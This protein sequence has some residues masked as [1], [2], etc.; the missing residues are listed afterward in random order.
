MMVWLLARIACAAVTLMVVGLVALGAPLPDATA[1]TP[2][3]SSAILSE[4]VGLGARPSVR[5]RRVQRILARRK[6]D[7]GSPGVDGRFGPLTA[8]AVRRLQERYGLVPDGIVGPKTL[9]LLRLLAPRRGT[10]RPARPQPPVQ[11]T[12]PRQ[13]SRTQESAATQPRPATHVQTAEQAGSID[14]PMVLAI[15]AALLAAAALAAALLG[16]QRSAKALALTSIERELLLEGHSDQAGVG[17]FRGLALATAVPADAADDP[18]RTRYLVDDPLKLAP[19]WVKGSD[20]RRSPSQLAEGERVIGYATT[21]SDATGEQQAFTR[22]EA[23]CEQRGWDLQEIIRD[24]RTGRMPDR[25]GLRHALEKIAAGEARA[26]VV[27][28]THN[29]ISSI[30]DLGA[31][32][33]WFRIAGAAL[34]AL[35]LELDTATVDGDRAASTLITLAGWESERA[36]GRIR[37]GLARVARP[38]RTTGHSLADRASL[39]ERIKAMRQ[40][41][42]TLQGIADQLNQEAIPTLRGE[43]AWRPSAVKRA[44]AEDAETAKLPDSPRAESRAEPHR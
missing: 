39:V 42:M 16:G 27:S 3:A 34:I 33:E 23:Q 21:D 37:S 30:T 38:D 10:Q 18:G 20:V 32:L 44:L 40:G 43:P 41:R 35:D 36:T 24:Q 9:R 28:D 11:Q 14:L 29:L 22:I 19:V 25:P 12:P 7:L 15:V 31:L 8:G 17:F 13:R 26:L 5:V 4:G 2:S 6:F 1:A